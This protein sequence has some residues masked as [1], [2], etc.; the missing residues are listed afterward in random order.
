MRGRKRTQAVTLFRPIFR[1]FY[2]QGS[3]EKEPSILSA[4]ELGALRLADYQDLHHEI[5][6]AQLKI[7]RP[8]FSRLLTA[9][10]K[11]T[12]ALLLFGKPIAVEMPQA[13]F[14][15]AYPSDD[16]FSIGT[17]ILSAKLIVIATI[18]AGKIKA[19]RFEENPSKEEALIDLLEG[20]SIVVCRAIGAKLKTR[21]AEKEIS[22]MITT[23]TTLE[24]IAAEL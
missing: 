9:A 7:T 12:A 3:H 14:Q 20:V 17:D 4:E 5:A 16:R 19:M 22:V 24:S 10:R 2:A 11:K 13:A 18:E 1:S 15:A 23:A 8:T 6:A 21:L